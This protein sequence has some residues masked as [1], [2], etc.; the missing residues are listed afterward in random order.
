MCS[1]ASAI[2]D[3]AMSEKI[4][5]VDDEP[6]FLT[7]YQLMLP[8]DLNPLNSDLPGTDP[9]HFDLDT[10]IG[11]AAGLEA[12]Q[13]HGPYSLVISDMRMPG[14]NGLEFLTCVQQAA[15][16]TV[17]MLLTGYS[18]IE[19][20]MNAVNRGQVFQYL[21]K[22]CE[23]QTLAEAVALGLSQYR[24]IR[25]EKELLEKTLM[26]A[27]E[28]LT[29]V[30]SAVS[31]E[32]FAQ[33]SH[34]ARCV[35][36]L[37]EKLQL[38]ST[39]CHQAAAMLSQLGCITLDP[40]LLQAAYLGAPLSPEDRSRYEAHAA[41]AQALLLNAQRLEPVAWM[42]GQQFGSTSQKPPHT[43]YLSEDD[44]RLGAKLLRVA[45]SF[46]S[47]KMRGFSIAEAILHLRHRAEFDQK[48]LDALAELQEEDSKMELRRVAVTKIK[49]GAILQQNVRNR[50]G[51][52]IVAKGQEVTPPVLVRLQHF[53][54]ARLID[55]EVLAWILI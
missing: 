35:R 40:E 27:I 25:A 26:G 51:V 23:A 14:M 44:M 9:K 2:E 3:R 41:V 19:T 1:P 37:V 20:V 53:S 16:E 45:S 48:L 31:P 18:D 52:L 29:E 32:A 17:R 24:L 7:G 10:A 8:R 49:V 42:I 6:A 34:I 54:E 46:E 36:H 39:W 55:H 4:L 38:H 47:L 5:F 30:L 11:G 12:I 21:A 28:V 33:S 13:T 43:P 15:P 50:G 22:P